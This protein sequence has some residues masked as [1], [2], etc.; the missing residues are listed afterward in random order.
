MKTFNFDT[1]PYYDCANC[2]DAA[3]YTKFGQDIRPR[4]AN[5]F[6]FKHIQPKNGRIL[7]NVIMSEY[8][9]DKMLYQY[10][11]LE[12][13]EIMTEDDSMVFLENLMRSNEILGVRINNYYCHWSKYYKQLNR[14]HMILII[15]LNKAKQILHV[16]DKY[17]VNEPQTITFEDF[18]QGVSSYIYYTKI[19][20]RVDIM[21]LDILKRSFELITE[22]AGEDATAD[23][24]QKLS[25]FFKWVAQIN[26]ITGD[27]KMIDASY[28]CLSITYIWWSRLAYTDFM[29]W[30]HEF[31]PLKQLIHE[32]EKCSELWLL[33]RNN[34]YKNLL[35]QKNLNPQRLEMLA[36]QITDI[37]VSCILQLKNLILKLENERSV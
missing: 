23:R 26:Y 15:E 22:G 12:F 13:T 7:D 33:L 10:S 20:K 28:F 9:I 4:F 17:V 19:K 27:L 31:E 6:N 21:P 37:E 25:D 34:I 5:K 35:Y 30:M 3:F 16:Y 29:R 36:E 11:S 2:I 1:K 18:K 24:Q 14:D 8:R 32:L